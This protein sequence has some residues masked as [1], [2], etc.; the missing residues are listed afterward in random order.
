METQCN[1]V[2]VSADEYQSFIRW[3]EDQNK[4]KE[5]HKEYMKEYMKERRMKDKEKYNEYQRQLYH[6]NKAKAAQITA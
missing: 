2:T 6:K 4:R 1:T 3:K 5:H